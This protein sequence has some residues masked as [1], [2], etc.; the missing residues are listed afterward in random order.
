MWYKNLNQTSLLQNLYKDIPSLTNIVIRVIKIEDNGRRIS[1]HFDMSVYADHPSE[2]WV[3]AGYNTVHI[4]M[5]F[6]EIKELSMQSLR[7]PY[8]GDIT[9]NS[10]KGDL[11]NIQVHGSIEMSFKAFTGSIENIDGYINNLFPTIYDL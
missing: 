1:I 4:T 10:V 3:E 6:F 11:L 8:L 5:K 2:D 7:P 9:I